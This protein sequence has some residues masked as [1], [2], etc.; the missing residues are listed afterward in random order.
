MLK[1]YDYLPSR[2]AWKVRLLLNH[3][4]LAYE[5]VPVSI[6][7]GEGRTP[8]FLRVNPSGKGLRWNWDIRTVAE[9]NHLR[10]PDEASDY[11]PENRHLRAKVHQWLSFGQERV[12]MTIGS[13][14][15]G[16]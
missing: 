2:N 12:E 10:L 14:I 15:T 6:F 9:S 11:L 8:A 13:C 4:G 7:E 16:P 5:S 3:L 1:L